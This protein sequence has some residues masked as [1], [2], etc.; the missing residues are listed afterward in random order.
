M[1]PDYY[2]QTP[3]P[4]CPN[5]IIIKEVSLESTKPKVE[6][7][8]SN[9][10][11]DSKKDESIPLPPPVSVKQNTAAPPPSKNEATDNKKDSNLVSNGT[12]VGVKR[13][14]F[15]DNK[16]KSMSVDVGAG[17]KFIHLLD[18]AEKGVEQLR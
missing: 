11:T 6:K 2:Q 9:S 8:N 7:R 13:Q 15:S 16:L 12:N 10:S 3:A 14:T 17:D 4:D 5:P 18:D 1:N